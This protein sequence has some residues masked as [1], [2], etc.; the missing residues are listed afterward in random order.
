[1]SEKYT[2][3]LIYIMKK[4]N[5]SVNNTEL[6]LENLR[7]TNVVNLLDIDDPNL[8]EGISSSSEEEFN[9]ADE[10]L[11]ISEGF[12]MMGKNDENKRNISTLNDIDD[13]P[14]D[15]K[16]NSQNLNI[17]EGCIKIE[18]EREGENENEKEEY[19][20]IYLLNDLFK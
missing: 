8:L 20:S 17:N 1:M 18:N 19:S 9:D 5:G 6:N 2:E 11:K 16:S 14:D 12:E 15:Q 13:M 7:Y 4:N 10:S 3:Y